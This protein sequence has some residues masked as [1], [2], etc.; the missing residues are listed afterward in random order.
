MIF[1]W[2]S[3][4]PEYQTFL[5]FFLNNS[6][7]WLLFFPKKQNDKWTRLKIEQNMANIH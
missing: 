1:Y 5:N 6:L 2:R 7:T 4:F 3:Q